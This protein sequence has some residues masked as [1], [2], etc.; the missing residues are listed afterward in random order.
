M[1][2]PTHIYSE[3]RGGERPSNG[4]KEF[5]DYVVKRVV[6]QRGSPIYSALLAGDQGVG[7]SRLLAAI[8]VELRR[9][10]LDVCYNIIIDD[11]LD[12]PHDFIIADD[13]AAYVSAWDWQTKVAKVLNRI[14]IL[15]R[16]RARYGYAIAAPRVEN[17]LK[18]FREVGEHIFL[19]GKLQLYYEYGINS[20]YD[21][22]AILAHKSTSLENYKT[23]L[24]YF[25]PW[26]PLRRWHWNW[27]DWP[28]AQ[29]AE[30][31]A[32]YERVQAQ[33]EKL[34]AE[35]TEKLLAGEGEE[36]E[37]TA[38]E[39]EGEKEEEES[40]ET[41]AAKK[42]FE[43][44]VVEKAIDIASYLLGRRPTSPEEVIDA[45]RAHPESFDVRFTKGKDGGERLVVYPRSRILGQSPRELFGTTVTHDRS[46]RHCYYVSPDRLIERLRKKLGE[47][48]PQ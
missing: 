21:V 44:E 27:A 30:W 29:D 32:E 18:P 46:G 12:A 11:C 6:E 42:R 40:E 47:P 39:N 41:P 38:E 33:R 24:L 28:W 13:M 48:S 34:F 16:N 4:A 31:R 10:G 14:H 35:L 36:G 37:E 25:G 43:D 45:M 1:S 8:A 2:W 7:K 3:E 23:Q 5:V 15:I 19:Y 9:A 20:K 22:T 17:I 26:R